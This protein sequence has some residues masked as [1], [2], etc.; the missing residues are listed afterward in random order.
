MQLKQETSGNQK[1][2]TQNSQLIS[3]GLNAQ[4]LLHLKREVVVRNFKWGIPSSA[5]GRTNG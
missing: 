5:D 3:V 4:T 1:R 2:L